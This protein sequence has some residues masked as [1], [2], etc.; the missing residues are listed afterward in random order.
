MLFNIEIKLYSLSF[1]RN[2]NEFFDKTI[3]T[4]DLDSYGMTKSLLIFNI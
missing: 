4:F 3:A 2:L 1:R